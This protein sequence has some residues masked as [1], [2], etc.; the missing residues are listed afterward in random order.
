M[1]VD[2]AA[3]AELEILAVI[4]DAMAE[5]R[6]RMGEVSWTGRA[7]RNRRP[8][9]DGS[10]PRCGAPTTAGK[11]CRSWP[12]RGG[13]RCREHGGEVPELAPWRP[14]LRVA[15]PLGKAAARW[16]S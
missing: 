7:S 4:G 10:R 11:P 12:V 8:A 2:D 3:R 1:T 6:A 15:D 5:A 13:V 9:K 16:P 14:P